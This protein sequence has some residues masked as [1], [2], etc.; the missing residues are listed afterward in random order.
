MFGKGRHNMAFKIDEN[1]NITM[2][3]GDTGRLVVNG[4]NTDQNYT[5]YFAIQDENRRP[6]GNEVNVESNMQPTVV[7]ELDSQLT[8]LLKV[9]EDEET[10]T[11][12]YGVK[13]CTAEGFEDTLS[14][15][16]SDMG[17]KNTITVYP[18]KVEGC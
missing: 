1:G 2:V 14:I 3:Q 6:V 7:F 5:V 12:Y 10:H 8:D 9:A 11:Y 16:G 15:G 4:L 17:V 18:K 13:T